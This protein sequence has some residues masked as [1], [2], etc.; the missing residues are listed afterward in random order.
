MDF[1]REQFHPVLSPVQAA[2]DYL[3]EHAEGNDLI[4]VNYG[5]LPMKVLAEPPH[6]GWPDGRNIGADAGLDCSE[7]FDLRSPARV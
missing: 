7:A 2:I 3:E 4:A 6:R 5:D 1:V